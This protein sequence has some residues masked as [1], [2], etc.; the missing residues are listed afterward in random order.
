MT[1][2]FGVLTS[3]FP[4]EVS[5]PDAPVQ[6]LRGVLSGCAL[7][8]TNT[9]LSRTPMSQANGSGEISPGESSEG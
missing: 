4:Y 1:K 2:H 9:A 6:A 3:C 8:D 7:F 5:I